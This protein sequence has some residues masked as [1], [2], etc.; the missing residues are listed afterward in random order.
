MIEQFKLLS[1][2]YIFVGMHGE[3]FGFS[4]LLTP[5]SGVIEL[6]LQGSSSNW[7]MEYLTKWSGH[8]YFFWANKAKTLEDKINKYIKV[9]PDPVIDVLRKAS[10]R[11]CSS[12]PHVQ[13]IAGG[14][15]RPARKLP[16]R[17]AAR[18]SFQDHLK[19]LNLKFH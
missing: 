14:R 17:A 4:V 5:G 2:T 8:H 6:F 15:E 13:P 3:A 10:D 7:H 11:V 9:L 19:S 1:E 18:C 12:K 16:Q